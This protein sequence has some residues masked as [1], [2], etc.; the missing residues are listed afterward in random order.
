MRH[1]GYRQ[2]VNRELAPRDRGCTSKAVYLSRREALS[3]RRHGKR[4]YAGLHPYRCRYCDGW[5]LGHRRRV[6]RSPA[7]GGR[8]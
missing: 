5:H 2:F 6:S 7:A 8:A 4:G 3:L 1:I